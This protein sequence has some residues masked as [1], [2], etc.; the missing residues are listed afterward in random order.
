MAGLL[1]QRFRW[2]FGTLQCLWKHRAAL[3]N[4]E[5]P[6]LGFVALPQ[7]W[8]FQIVLTAVSPLVDLAIIWS[9]VWALYAQH[10]HPVEW[11]PDDFLRSVFYWAAFIFLD[12]SAGALGMALERRAPWKD[13]RLAAGAALRLPPADVLRG[14]QV[15]RHR[16]AR[17]AGQ[18]GQAGAPGDGV[19]G[20]AGRAPPP[21]GAAAA[22]PTGLALALG[23]AESRLTAALVLALAAGLGAGAAARPVTEPAPAPLVDPITIDTSRPLNTFT[24]AAALGAALDGMGEGD[25]ERLLTHYN[26]EQM[27]EAGLRRVAYRTRPELGIEVWHW[28][29]DGTWSDPVRHQGYWTGSDNPSRD[30][31]V[32]WGYS[33]PR[34]GDTIDNAN[35]T[36]YSR[37]DDG[38][39][40]SFWK[41]NPYLDRRFTGLAASRPQWI[42]LSFPKLTRFDAARILW[43]QPF[44]RHFLVQY[45][46]GDDGFEEGKQTV[47]D[48]GR[49]T[50][51]PLGDV[52]VEGAPGEAVMRLADRPI[53]SHFIR[54]LMLQSSES[55]P[56]DSTDIRDRLGYAV[57][58]VGVGVLGA[59]G[60]FRD[61]V[62]HGPSR[63]TQTF[64]QVS[65]TDPWHRAVD[66]DPATEQPGLGFVFASGLSGG[67]PM[68]IPV[69]IWH[70]TP[71]DGAAEVRYI[72]R[73]GWPVDALELGEEPDG[74]FIRPE[75]Y[76]DLYLE[77]AAAIHAVDPALKLGGPSM[78]GPFTGLWPDTE[79]GDGWAGRFVAEL[80]AR[81]ALSELQFFSFEDYAFE[82]VCAPSGPLLRAGTRR[83][84]RALTRLAAEGVPTSIPWI[85]SEY[86]F[87]PFSG[88]EM[89]EAPSALLA[90][91]IVGHFLS[92]GGAAAYMFGYPPDD[93]ANQKF[94]CAGYGNMM[95]WETGGDD[96]RARWPMPVFFAERM[97][98]EDWGAPGDAPHRLY[99]AR[100]TLADPQ[101]RPY[102][103]AYPL[104]SPGRPMVGHAGQSRRARAPTL[105]R[106]RSRRAPGGR[107]FARPGARRAVLAGPVR[108][109]RPRRSEPPVPR[110]AAGPLRPAG[111]P[112]AGAAGDVADRG[113][114]RRSGALRRPPRLRLPPGGSYKARLLNPRDPKAFMNIHEHQAKAVLAEFGVPVPRG[115]PAF[116]VDEA[117]AAAEK[118]GGPVWV[119]KAQIHAG[120]RG[121]G[122]GVK[123]ARSID[124]V[125]DDRRQDARHDPRHPPDRAEGPRG[126]PPL[127]RGRRLDRQGILPLAAGRPRDQPR[128]GGGLHRGRH[129]HRGGRP[130][131]AG[132][133][134]H[135]HDRSG[136]R[137]LAASRPA[138]GARRWA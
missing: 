84:D 111:R 29:E 53:A 74:Q 137:R 134:P 76:A 57:R 21:P 95:L 88:R 82:D 30:P 66:R 129:G 98:A 122:G 112:D 1:K 103:T 10:Y 6:V 89:S 23:L 41:S 35:N 81:G 118:L 62:R 99:G 11:S 110:P 33:L 3:F 126:A 45:W 138:A 42:V 133:H 83:M 60:R 70:D 78:Q 80:K 117:V 71:E 130:R 39:P 90:A 47:D 94:R 87:S 36:G 128:G 120:G 107:P 56:P 20:I 114:R 67:G 37:L 97:M 96:G 9:V 132:A 54:I 69:G 4:R 109:A 28:S 136:D 40:A 5:R 2:S 55:G 124:E 113:Q 51:F 13:L 18:L 58:E 46:D 65:S 127:H 116:S 125:R 135:L 38:D 102:V 61:A 32:T 44:A 73:R 79:E 15:D 77:A 106:S 92:R 75:D 34:R 49:W 50:T 12:L 119:V 85:I 22:V 93:P 25:V 59:D 108:L 19:D 27:R 43:G 86:G 17:R 63:F 101:G 68:M 105:R 48:P 123:L 52:T 31:K 91:D 7:I 115:Y 26:I 72:E 14:G 16:D 24:P 64:A 131:D 121:K 104:L 100:A 8:L